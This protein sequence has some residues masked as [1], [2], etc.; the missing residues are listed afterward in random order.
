[1][2]VFAAIGQLA[3]IFALEGSKKWIIRE[4]VTGISG[5]GSGAPRASG[6]K[7]S[8]GTRIRARPY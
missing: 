8:R 7:K 4:G 1:M 6:V 2:S 3:R 5:T